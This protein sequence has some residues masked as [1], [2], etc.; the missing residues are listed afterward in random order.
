MQFSDISDS[1]A[2]TSYSKFKWLIKLRARRE[3]PDLFKCRPLRLK[4]L[5]IEM[6]LWSTNPQLFWLQN[7]LMTLFASVIL[8]AHVSSSD[9]PTRL[10]I[11]IFAVDSVP[12]I[13]A[14]LTISSAQAQAQAQSVLQDLRLLVSTWRIIS[15]GF[16]CRSGFTWSFISSLVHPGKHD[17]LTLEFLDNFWPW[18]FLRIEFPAIIISCW[19]LV[20]VCSQSALVWLAV[21]VD[22][23]AST[24]S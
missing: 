8:L 11:V 22:P 3:V 23:S 4:W 10:D 13:E 7:C 14:R 16:L 20:C 9:L 21:H 18:R 5:F 2:A 6:L 24:V 1:L 12:T 17:I 19:R 15:S